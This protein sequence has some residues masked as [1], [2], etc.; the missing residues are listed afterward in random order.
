MYGGSMF[1]KSVDVSA[2]GKAIAR[3]EAFW[4]MECMSVCKARYQPFRV[5]P[6]EASAG[7]N[8]PGG[9]KE[10]MFGCNSHHAI[11]AERIKK[12]GLRP[13]WVDFRQFHGS[14]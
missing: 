12:H 6:V 10:P 5:V 3:V 4:E 2:Q 14:S 9:K 11:R 1:C 13:G 8:V 7:K